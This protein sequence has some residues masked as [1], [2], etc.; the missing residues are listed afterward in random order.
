[1]LGHEPSLEFIRA[2]DFAGQHVVAA[3]VAEIVGLLD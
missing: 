1:M 2:D 3:F